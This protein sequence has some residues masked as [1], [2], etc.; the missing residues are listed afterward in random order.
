VRLAHHDRAGGAQAR[1]RLGVALGGDAAGG[2]RPHRRHLGGQVGVVLDS[3]RHAEQRSRV[4]GAPA[5]VGLVGLGQ[6]ALGQDDA[7]RVD[8]PVDARDLVERGLDDLAGGHLARGNQPGLARGAGVGELG[9]VH[10]R[11]EH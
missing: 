2:D 7:E 8:P 9:R 5:G 10:G 3:D 4:A 11:G 1:D 6:R